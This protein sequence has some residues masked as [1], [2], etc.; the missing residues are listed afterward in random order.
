[1]KKWL[2][3]PFLKNKFMR[4]AGGMPN[5]RGK[6]RGGCTATRDKC[7]SIIWREIGKSLKWRAQK[8]SP[9]GDNSG[10]TNW[11]NKDLFPECVIGWLFDSRSS[12]TPFSG[13]PPKQ[14]LAE[15]KS[16]ILKT[17][18]NLGWAKTKIWTK[19]SNWICQEREN[20]C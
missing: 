19:I 17:R 4:V 20:L 14:I 13:F 10:I 6:S 11:W 15:P 3:Q 16:S 9:G 2:W 5:R 18:K 1:M 8:K 12:L 7:Y